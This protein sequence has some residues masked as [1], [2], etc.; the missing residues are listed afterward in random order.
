MLL[1]TSRSIL[2]PRSRPPPCPWYSAVQMTYRNLVNCLPIPEGVQNYVNSSESKAIKSSLQALCTN[3][4]I[5]TCW[6]SRLIKNT[7]WVSHNCIQSYSMNWNIMLYVYIRVFILFSESESWTV[8]LCRI[9]SL[10]LITHLPVNLLSNK[11][12]DFKK[13][14]KKQTFNL[15]NESAAT[16]N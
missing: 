8:E 6:L 9:S 5:F 15:S 1:F 4:H 10:S 3:R 14:T 2:L 12:R 16:N 13:S 7:C 11:G